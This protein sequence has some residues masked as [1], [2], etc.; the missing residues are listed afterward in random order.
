MK[1]D[2]TDV[3]S[4]RSQMWLTCREQRE[5]NTEQARDMVQIIYKV[6]SRLDDLGL[7]L[8]KRKRLGQIVHYFSKK[9]QSILSMVFE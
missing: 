7:K 5:K 3:R 4:E 1:R 2:M 8:D 6:L 9:K